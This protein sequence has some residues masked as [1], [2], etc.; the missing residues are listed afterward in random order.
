MLTSKHPSLPSST[1]DQYS[2]GETSYRSYREVSY[3]L[4]SD[5]HNELQPAKTLLRIYDRQVDDIVTVLID[6]VIDISL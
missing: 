2:A 4:Q 5:I 3:A 6:V 1:L